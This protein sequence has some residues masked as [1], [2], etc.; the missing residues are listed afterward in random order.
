MT[1]TYL[2]HIHVRVDDPKALHAAAL[3]HCTVIDGL[4]TQEALDLIGE[5]E[6][7]DVPACLIAILDPCHL[8]GC[9]IYGSE[10]EAA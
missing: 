7:P 5:P 9:T 6:D 2:V 1:T 10:A 3:Q 8:R 4:P